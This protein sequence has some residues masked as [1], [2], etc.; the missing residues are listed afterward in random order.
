MQSFDLNPSNSHIC[1]PFFLFC[2]LLLFCCPI[3]LVFAHVRVQA[4]LL[5]SHCHRVIMSRWFILAKHHGCLFSVL[6]RLS[7][8]VS[9]NSHI[10]WCCAHLA[11]VQVPKLLRSKCLCVD[12]SI[13]CYS[14]IDCD[15]NDPL[16]YGQSPRV[17]WELFWSMMLIDLTNVMT[18]RQAK[19][20]NK[21]GNIAVW[22][23]SISTPILTLPQLTVS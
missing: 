7:I 16:F 14:F 20:M 6:L 3:I 11:V 18:G 10:M 9:H 12:R 1:F 4:P 2:H 22:V 5:F 8:P 17:T 21:K 19:K 13:L 15:G 23:H